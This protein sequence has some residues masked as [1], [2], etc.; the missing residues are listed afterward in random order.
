MFEKPASE[1]DYKSEGIRYRVVSNYEQAYRYN[2]P[3]GHSAPKAEKFIDINET[4]YKSQNRKREIQMKEMQYNEDIY[5]ER[6]EEESIWSKIG[7]FIL[8][9]IEIIT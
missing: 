1:K 2:S 3:N 5:N 9:I 6:E 7:H 8:V 4:N